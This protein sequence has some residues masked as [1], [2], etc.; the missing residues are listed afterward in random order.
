VALPL[1]QELQCRDSGFVQSLFVGTINDF[2]NKICQSR[3]NATQQ[4]TSY[5]ITSSARDRNSSG[6]VSPSA[7][8]V[9]RLTAS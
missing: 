7:F 5:S 2:C 8:A 1:L 3:P 4:R 6:I 9:M